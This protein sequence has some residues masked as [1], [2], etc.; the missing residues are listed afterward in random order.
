MSAD[1]DFVVR[2]WRLTP[3]GN[4][5]ATVVD[6][7]GRI[8][9]VTITRHASAHADVEAI[10]RDRLAALPPFTVYRQ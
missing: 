1:T 10:I 7:H 6:M 2:S 8:A 4:A 5:R 3:A 9:H